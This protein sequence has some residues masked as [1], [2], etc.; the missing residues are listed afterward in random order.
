MK[1]R[2]YTSVGST[3]DLK[4]LTDLAPKLPLFCAALGLDYILVVLYFRCNNSN[5]ISGL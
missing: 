5:F 3:L 1:W 2:K 4:P